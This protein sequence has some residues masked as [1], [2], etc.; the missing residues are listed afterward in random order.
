MTSKHRWNTKHYEKYT[1]M[2][3]RVELY[4][5]Y[6]SESWC[7]YRTLLNSKNVLDLGCGNGAMSSISKKINNKIKYLGVDHQ[8]NLIVKAKKRFKYASFDSCDV[9]N[10]LKKNNKTFDTVMAWSVIKSFKNWK[11]L[12]KLMISCSKKYILFDQRVTNTKIE[13]F[14]TKTLSAAYGG[15]EGPL[16]C[17]GYINLR[18][19]LLTQKKYLRKIEIMAY[20]S[21]WGEN[22]NYN[23]KSKTFVA[24]IVLH[25]KI[26][27]NSR[28]EGIYEQLP[29]SLK[30]KL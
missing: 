25:K 26:N 22:I 5:L 23:L 15:I 29:L 30:N 13:K 12:I 10:F 17:I 28:F 27:K 16:L 18:N 7:L 4:K 14:E 6:P 8:I 20:E 3:N 2:L 24:T 21:E 19:F 1:S 11:S 9:D